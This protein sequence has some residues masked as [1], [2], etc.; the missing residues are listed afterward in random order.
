[1][2]EADSRN[3]QGRF[4]SE[5]YTMQ[6]LIRNSNAREAR[7]KEEAR[8][9]L[10]RQRE[11][12][13]EEMESKI[14][15]WVDS[16]KQSLSWMYL[17]GTDFNEDS[18][19]KTGL[20]YEHSATQLESMALRDYLSG[21]LE[22]EEIQSMKNNYK[23]I[24]STDRKKNWRAGLLQDQLKN[25]GSG[26]NEFGKE[27][28]LEIQRQEAIANAA[29]EAERKK[30]E[31]GFLGIG[32][33][34]KCGVK[35]AVG[36][37]TGF[38]GDVMG[39]VGQV[40]NDIPL[41]GNVA[42]G[43][44]NAYEETKKFWDDVGQAIKN[45]GDFGEW[46]YNTGDTIHEEVL[47]QAIG[48][49]VPDFIMDADETTEMLTGKKIE[50]MTLYDTSEMIAAELSG[51]GEGLLLLHDTVQA[52]QAK[53]EQER[54]ERE[55]QKLTDVEKEME[56]QY[57]EPMR[58][59]RPQQQSSKPKGKTNYAYKPPTVERDTVVKETK[60]Y[61]PPGPIKNKAQTAPLQPK[62]RPTGP[63]TSTSS[64]AKQSMPST[65]KC[66]VPRKPISC[67]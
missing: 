4:I 37:V 43:I 11:R 31:G 30:C 17:F 55:Q 3:Y 62:P 52:G 2:G 5:D 60:P 64:G 61:L 24:M 10:E 57:G 49:F 25:N 51:V 13:I 58:L 16:N 67:N 50:D 23:E 15:N 36:A 53:T 47:R 45:S 27:N 32:N 29:E 19:E 14:E 59:I 20:I 12:E 40:I 1:M 22:P 39:E 66:G 46:V 44:S 38:I 26:L 35:K 8:L 34:I 54:L 63:T 18:Y 33:K 28:K 56:R 21:F 42:K 48:K 65:K 9:R 7:G 6:D 41:L